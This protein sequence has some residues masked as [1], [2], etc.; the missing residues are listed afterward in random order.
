MIAH[1]MTLQ[2]YRRGHII[3]TKL[4]QTFSMVIDNQMKRNTE[5][6]HLNDH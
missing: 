5:I 1:F 2:Y 4:I 3:I 6:C